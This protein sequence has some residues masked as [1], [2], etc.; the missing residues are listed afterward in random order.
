MKFTFKTEKATGRYGSFFPDNH[1][2]K[3]K[4]KQ[5]GTISDKNGHPIRLMVIKD[6]ITED[7]NPNCN[8][9]W[10]QLKARFTSVEDAKTFLNDNFEGINQ[11][12][13]LYMAED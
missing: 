13:N 8:W 7:G 3:L 1:Y 9:K 4:R 2:I 6:D 5:V 11:T 12:W 10:I